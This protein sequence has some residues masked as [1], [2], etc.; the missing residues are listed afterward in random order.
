LHYKKYVAYQDSVNRIRQL[1]LDF[2]MKTVTCPNDSS[3]G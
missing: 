3:F 2:S 1:Q